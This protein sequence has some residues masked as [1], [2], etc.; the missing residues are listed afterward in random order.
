[1]VARGPPHEP[2]PRG[3]GG[4]PRVPARPGPTSSSREDER[5]TAVTITRAERTFG[6]VR[7]VAGVSIDIRPGELFTLLGPSGCG[8]TTL[9]RMV[10]GFCDL[11][12]GSIHFGE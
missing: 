8:K 1:E 9:L 6:A 3:A 2:P 12:Q 5:L 4:G 7:A 10:A 11:D